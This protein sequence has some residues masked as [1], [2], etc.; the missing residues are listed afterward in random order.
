MSASFVGAGRHRVCRFSM[1][2]TARYGALTLTS[3]A[4]L[5]R[6][7]PLQGGAK[8]EVPPHAITQTSF[9]AP[10]SSCLRHSPGP[11]PPRSRSLRGASGRPHS[12]P[13]VAG[14]AQTVRPCIRWRGIGRSRQPHNVARF[15]RPALARVVPTNDEPCTPG[16]REWL[17][18]VRPE[19]LVS[20]AHRGL[21]Q[22]RNCLTRG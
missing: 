19:P 22:R 16:A 14:R 7:F 1:R 21:R 18:V 15:H 5:W 20:A 10:P 6:A 12:A 3:V 4:V 11:S 17:R 2:L 9:P 13:A 8:Y